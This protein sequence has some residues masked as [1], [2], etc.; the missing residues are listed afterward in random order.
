MLKGNKMFAEVVG[1]EFVTISTDTAVLQVLLGLI[2]PFVNK[3]IYFMRAGMWVKSPTLS[4]D[5]ISNLFFLCRPKQNADNS[6]C[7]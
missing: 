1:D 7:H 6:W 5:Y 2:L 4:F 3:S